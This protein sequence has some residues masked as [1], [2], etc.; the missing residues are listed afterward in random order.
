[1]KSFSRKTVATLSCASLLAVALSGCLG[2]GDTPAATATTTVSGVAMAGKFLS[3]RVCAYKVVSGTPATESISCGDIVPATSGY[4]IGIGSYTGDVVVQVES[5][6]T[7]DDEATAGDEATGTALTRSI[8]SFLMIAQAGQAASVAVTPLTE[9]A[10]IDA[11]SFDKAAIDSAATKIAGQFG[12]P[13]TA[14]LFSTLPQ[15]SA[16]EGNQQVYKEALRTLSQLQKAAKDAGDATAT[17]DNPAAYVNTML[18]ELNDDTKKAAMQTR[19]QSTLTAALPSYCSFSAGTMVCTLPSS[20]TGGFSGGTSTLTITASANGVPI[21]PIVLNNVP[22][23]ADEASF[24]ADLQNEAAFANLGTQGGGTLRIDSCSYAGNSGTVAATLV[25]T[26]PYNMTVP[27]T[28]AFAYS[29]ASSGTNTSGTNTGTTT[30]GASCAAG[31]TA[32]TY[33]AEPMTSSSADPFKTKDVACFTVSSSALKIV[34]TLDNWGNT[35]ETTLTGG[36]PNTA[37]TAP[38]SAYTFVDPATSYKY[39]AVLNAGTLKEINVLKT[40]GTY[41]GGTYVGQFNDKSS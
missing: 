33:W 37:V 9:A 31:S 26:D 32:L 27:Y 36:T 19:I 3:G 11:K 38:Y 30:T 8:R 40:S 1:M 20:T 17:P 16:T 10:I 14:S 5:G 13:T 29:A 34:V 24:C 4:S 41:A 35:R 25:I 23:P 18:A 7:Y 22:A 12:L 15:V 39:E 2:G 6:A 21:A 28:V